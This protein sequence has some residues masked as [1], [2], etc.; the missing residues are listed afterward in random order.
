MFSM[1]VSLA[2]LPRFLVLD[3]VSTVRIQME[4]ETPSCEIDVEPQNLRSGRSFVLL[5]GLRGGPFLQRMRLSGRA[6]ILFRPK[7]AGEYL[8][9]VANPLREPLVLRLRGHNIRTR[10]GA[11]RSAR[12]RRVAAAHRRTPRAVRTRAARRVRGAPRR[13]LSRPSRSPAGVRPSAP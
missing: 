3:P 13:T 8:L 11:R 2:R 10:A 1:A 12:R 7:V 4:L 9:M 5:I 6:R